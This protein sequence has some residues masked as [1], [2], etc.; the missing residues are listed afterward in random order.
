MARKSRA[1]LDKERQKYLALK[2]LTKSRGWPVLQQILKDKFKEALDVVCAP[3]SV[4]AEV[5]ARGAIKLIKDLTDTIDR[6]MGF[7][8]VAQDEYMKQYFNPPKGQEPE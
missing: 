2:D 4:K 5:E 3:K 7:G 1:E 8:K 6:E